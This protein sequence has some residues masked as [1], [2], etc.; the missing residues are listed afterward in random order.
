MG[1]GDR[2]GRLLGRIPRADG[3]KPRGNQAA[4]SAEFLGD[5][6]HPLVLLPLLFGHRA[7]EAWDQR[8]RVLIALYLTREGVG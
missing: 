7:V 6:P 2:R 4:P 8:F 1:V 5:L 3:S